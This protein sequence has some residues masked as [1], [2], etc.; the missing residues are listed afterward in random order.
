MVLSFKIWISSLCKLSEEHLSLIV[1]KCFFSL[2]FFTDQILFYFSEIIE[3]L[4]F[5]NLLLDILD[6]LK[7]ISRDV[8]TEAVHCIPLLSE[9]NISTFISMI[10]ME[11]D[12]EVRRLAFS[13]IAC[14]LHVRS[15]TVQQR[16]QLLKAAF[17]SEDG[18]TIILLIYNN[19]KPNTSGS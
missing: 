1:G 18:T 13:R 15:L 7:D 6:A 2:N 19:F 10:L 14:N 17:A 16:M 11:S 12:S 3:A 9:N 8:R 5:L 4:F